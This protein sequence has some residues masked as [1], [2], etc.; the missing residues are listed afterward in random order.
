M[1]ILEK[2]EI[3]KYLGNFR[4]DYI[5]PTLDLSETIDKP[6][7]LFMN[8]NN[9]LYCVLKS[10]T[11]KKDF[12]LTTLF[13]QNE[14]KYY[15]K[16][17]KEGFSIILIIKLNNKAYQVLILDKVILK[18]LKKELFFTELSLKYWGFENLCTGKSEL[19]WYLKD[20]IELR[21]N[22]E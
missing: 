15:T 2:K 10:F 17:L 5:L 1:D 14:F 18:S 16:W 8:S 22:F 9:Y 19:F 4:S 7:F 12:N 3:I 11:E 13:N 20:I 6:D 21:R